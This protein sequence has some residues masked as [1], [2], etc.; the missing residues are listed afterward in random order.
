MVDAEQAV[1]EGSEGVAEHGVS[2]Y[3]RMS[4]I[5]GTLA[6]LAYAIAGLIL[7]MFDTLMAPVRAFAS[8]MATFI[9][10]TLLAPVRVTDAGAAA[11]VR[12][13]TE[14]AAA[15]LGPFAFPVSVLVVVIAMYLFLAF[16]RRISIS[17]TQLIRRDN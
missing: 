12:S 5:G 4:V 7:G 9:G 14:G 11:S 2:Q 13:F 8:G 15:A 1:Q 17:P 16:L 6:A 10:G 3:A